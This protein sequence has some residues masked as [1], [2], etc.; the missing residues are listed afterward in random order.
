MITFPHGFLTTVGAAPS[1]FDNTYSVDF[2]GVN[3]YVDCGNVASIPSA[4]ELTISTW[5]K[6]DAISS[7]K[8]LFGD[9]VSSGAA[10]YLSCELW[11]SNDRFYLELRND[12][13]SFPYCYLPSFSS[14]I[15]Q[16]VWYN[17]VWVFDGSGVANAD[18]IKLYING[19]AK[20]LTFS[21]TMPTALSSGIGDFWIGNGAEYNTPFN[22]NID[23]VSIFDSVVSAATLYNGG[24]PTDLSSLSP[25]AW[26]RMGDGDT[27]PMLNNEQAYSNRSVD[28]DGVDDYVDLGTNVLFDSTSALSVSGWVK[29][30]SYSPSYPVMIILKTDQATGFQI[31]FSDSA[32]YQGVWIGSSSN[33]VRLSTLDATL[34]ATLIDGNW[35][36]IVLTYDGVS[37][38]TASSYTLYVDGS[39]DSLGAASAYAGVP[40]ESRI[41]KGSTSTTVVNG[42]IDEVA[43]FDSELTSGN[44]TTIY[45]GGVPADLSSLSPTSW[46]KMGDGDTYPT[47]TDS[48]SGSN[49]GTM[50]NMASDDITG[51]QT[52]GIMTNMVSGDIVADVPS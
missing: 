41:G 47:L 31:G 46:W 22:G 2:D 36:H 37:R 25:V 14:H 45:N 17:A 21:G 24:V 35:H 32:G 52:T 16:G 28:F 27:Y 44:V 43:I 19:V 48:G 1:A 51:A 9:S 38:T 39:P 15:T 30:T 10:P 49:D 3:D 8:V 11:G 40:N 26:Y 4:T 12:S 13:G 20:T 42:N 7:N 34:A 5:F 6:D 29:L 23:E 50:T 18:K 33:F